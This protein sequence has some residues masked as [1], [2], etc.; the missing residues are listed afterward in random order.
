MVTRFYGARYRLAWCNR[1]RQWWP[2][3]KKGT[4]AAAPIALDLNLT[5]KLDELSDDALIVLRDRYAGAR[6][7]HYTIRRN[8]DLLA[9]LAYFLLEISIASGSC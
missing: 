8:F 6:S 9:I 7:M 2:D 4:L 1:C 3:G 5:K